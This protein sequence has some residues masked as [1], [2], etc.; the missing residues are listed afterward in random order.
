MAVYGVNY[1]E[2]GRTGNLDYKSVYFSRRYHGDFKPED[3]EFNSGDFVKD[4]Y[5]LIKHI[6]HNTDEYEPVAGSSSVDH[7]F[8]DGADELYD[9]AYLYQKEGEEYDLHY[10][11]KPDTIRFFVPKNT[12]PTWKELKKMCGDVK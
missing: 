4:W 1:N 6:I 2:S 12:K 9:D 7:F 11:Y 3:I 8:M 5:D 10:E